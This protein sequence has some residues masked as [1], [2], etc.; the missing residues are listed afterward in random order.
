MNSH[1]RVAR[2][3]SINHSFVCFIAGLLYFR[4]ATAVAVA[5][6]R[7]GCKQP[8]GKTIQMFTLAETCVRGAAQTNQTKHA[9][10]VQEKPAQPKLSQYVREKHTQTRRTASRDG[11]TNVNIDTCAGAHFVC[12]I[13]AA[14][15][16]RCSRMWRV[17]VR[18]KIE[19][20]PSI[21]TCEDGEC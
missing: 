3:A 14:P 17:H 6:L 11:V 12:D 21:R 2:R 7:G 20:A 15:A 9:S 4:H 13:R 16:R 8:N 19:H 18:V 1:T 10:D 5:H